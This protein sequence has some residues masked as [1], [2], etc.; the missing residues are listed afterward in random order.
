[1]YDGLTL[2]SYL[3]LWR[4]FLEGAK[5]ID[6]VV[7]DAVDRETNTSLEDELRRGAA[8]VFVSSHHGE[9]REL[10]FVNP[11]ARSAVF[12]W[13]G[14]GLRWAKPRSR[15][16]R[17]DA[18]FLRRRLAGA[19]I[20]GVVQHGQDRV[21]R[22][23]LRGTGELGEPVVLS[24]H[25]LLIGRRANLV[26]EIGGRVVYAWRAGPHY[27]EPH[28][29]LK[30]GVATVG[31]Y[32]D[33]RRRGVIVLKRRRGL[34]GELIVGV[35]GI[36]SSAVGELFH[37]LD[38]AP[39]VVFEQLDEVTLDRLA[40]VGDELIASAG[41]VR[42][43]P[44]EGV[45]SALPL[46]SLGEARPVAEEDEIGLVAG[47]ERVHR[48]GALV[49]RLTG[50]LDR[51][52]GRL[53]KAVRDKRDALEKAAGVN[54]LQL[55][56]QL[57]LT[58]PDVR[59]PA[60]ESIALP[61]GDSV[62]LNPQISR[63]ANAQRL[64]KRAKRNRRARDH[65]GMLED[66]IGSLNAEYSQLTTAVSPEAS[67]E[68]IAELYARYTERERPTSKGGHA[69]PA[70]VGRRML[71]GGFTLYWGRD[72]HANQYVTFR[73]AR[74]GDVWFHVQQGSGAHV[75]VRRPGRD[76]PLPP[77]VIEEA[78]R[79]ALRYSALRTAAHVPVVYTE[80]R[81]IRHRRGAPGAVFYEREKVIYIE[82]VKN[83]R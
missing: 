5:V 52:S 46:R 23:D 37:R 7:L 32:L 28:H 1:M 20:V 47:F 49:A 36:S 50:E 80:R 70:K 82:N 63:L 51:I 61:D 34:A 53:R 59:E 81:Y 9:E 21:V 75:I 69:L 38:L 72:G 6:V 30:G 66:L 8:V 27:G 2:A 44:E 78:A 57:L 35:D 45:I 60:P 48:R 54:D 22:L 13:K 10:V 25:I 73:L 65:A 67:L 3:S 33:R 26:L 11:G 62:T 29:P 76:A 58:S 31:E 79:L 15:R 4:P 14:K 16:R 18:G 55:A 74:P 19:R 17:Q 41:E 71:P 64:F 43:Y 12:L 24:L 68:V 77:E 56:G 83:V 40:V 42:F 39:G